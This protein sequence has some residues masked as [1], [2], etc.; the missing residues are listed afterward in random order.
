M[1]VSVSA[2]IQ[3]HAKIKIKFVTI[4][5]ISDYSLEKSGIFSA[6]DDAIS[7]RDWEKGERQIKSIN[8]NINNNNIQRWFG[9]RLN[10]RI[11][12]L[13]IRWLFSFYVN[14]IYYDWTSNSSAIEGKNWQ[15]ND[16]RTV[17][18]FLLFLLSIFFLL[19]NISK[20]AF[21]C[22]LIVECMANF[23]YQWLI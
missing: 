18:G 7:I 20:C 12:A 14:P 22:T 21:L 15:L 23:E 6:N 3:V 16:K 11:H 13:K 2:I 17:H 19:S 9:N 10:R 8:N 5:T 1:N 4:C